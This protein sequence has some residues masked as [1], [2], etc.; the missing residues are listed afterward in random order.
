MCS[1]CSDGSACASSPL[2]SRSTGWS[3]MNCSSSIC[4]S[5]SM[6]CS[7]SICCCGS[8]NCSSC[9]CCCGS[10]SS[11]SSGIDDECV[12]GGQQCFDGRSKVRITGKAY[13]DISCGSLK[14]TV[15]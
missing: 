9:T 13:I 3:S 10:G 11:C 2:S 4:C 7:I 1:C 8:V 12:G 15:S 5:C 14:K 6:N